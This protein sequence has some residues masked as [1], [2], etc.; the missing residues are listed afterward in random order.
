M[1]KMSLR[2]RKPEDAELQQHLVQETTAPP[3]SPF[4]FQ[5]ALLQCEDSCQ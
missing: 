2:R 1:V 4:T 3:F 5:S